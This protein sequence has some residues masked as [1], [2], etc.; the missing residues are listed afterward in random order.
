M[1]DCIFCKI[2]KGDIP[3]KKLYEDELVY[4]FYDINPEAPV[5]F[6]IIPKEHIKSV[7]ELNEKNINVVSH[8]FKVIN[9]LVVELDIAE[10]GYRIVNNC[11]EDGGQT[12]NHIHFHILAGRNLQWPPG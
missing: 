4:S 1:G 2:I 6:L 3:S 8:I 10:S 12:V 7:N 9:K 11:G 5:H